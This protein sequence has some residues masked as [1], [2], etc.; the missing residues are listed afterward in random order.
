[1]K[2]RIGLIIIVITLV[3]GGVYFLKRNKII[4][5]TITSPNNTAMY[6]RINV[7]LKDTASAYIIYTDEEEGISYKTPVS[8]SKLSHN[9]DLLLLK[10]N[11]KYT[12]KVYIDNFLHQKSKKLSFTTK[13]QKSW[14]RNRWFSDKYPHDSKALGNG[15]VLICFGRLPGYIAI[16]DN[17]GIIRWHWQINDI[18]VRAASFTPR[19]TILAMLRPPGLDVIDD[20]PLTPTQIKEEEHKRPMRRGAIG[21]A[22]GT[23]IAEI[24]LTGK[25]IRRIKLKD[26][27][28]DKDYK[29]LHHEVIM[30]KNNLIHTLYRPKKVAQYKVNGITKT[31]TLG[32][33]G[34]M[35]LDTLGNI[36]WTW[37]AW[38]NWDI[39]SDKYIDRY[40]YDRF[41][42]N[43]FCIDKDGNY[44]LSVPIEDQIWKLNSKTKKIEW[45]LGRGGDIKMDPTDYFSFQHAPHFNSKG[46][47]MVFDN[48]L[49]NYRSGT[50]AFK[51]N[52][53]D[54]SATTTLRAI[55]PADKYT[56]R[57]GCGFLLPN[58]NILQT[59]SKTGSIVVTSKKGDVL[60]ESKMHYVPYRAIY[61]PENTWDKYFKRIK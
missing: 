10:P 27:P 42:M 11:T 46:E 54:K 28:I 3:L 35:V 50:R 59:S 44:I 20:K 52:E 31:D 16:M 2:K 38:E 29:I 26:L 53:K 47:L 34:I 24:S 49:Y 51:I 39:D 13:E 25:L 22:G 33:D 23:E 43:G 41:H 45:K 61:V 30:D 19:G 8:S 40:K 56:C 32:G 18:G 14:L 37:S 55:M 12:Y 6:N 9:F 58:G 21:F 60:W 5:I 17:K 4:K 1:M 36:K 7:E 48:G 57:M 15:M